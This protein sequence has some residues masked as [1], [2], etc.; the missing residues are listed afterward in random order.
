MS[1]LENDEHAFSIAAAITAGART[2]EDIR[3]KSGLGLK[4]YDAAYR[5]PPSFCNPSASLRYTA[6]DCWVVMRGEGI[7]NDSGPGRRGYLGN[8]MLLVERSEFGGVEFS[9]GDSYIETMS[10]QDRK[11]GSPE[12]WIRAAINHHL[13]FT[14][15]QIS[16]LFGS[17]AVA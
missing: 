15:R 6:D 11:T 3:S 10:R 12:T 4:T 8:A 14:A 9:A 1:E 13:T 2:S 7:M 5:E 17:A 16:T